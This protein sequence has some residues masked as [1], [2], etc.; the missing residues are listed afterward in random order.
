MP[1]SPYFLLTSTLNVF[2]I[3]THVTPLERL[4][5]PDN[6]TTHVTYVTPQTQA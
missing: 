1:K 3:N 2:F 6:P 5:L 4:I